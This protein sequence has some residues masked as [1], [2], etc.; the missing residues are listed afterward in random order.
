MFHD[1]PAKMLERMR[2]LERMNEA[3]KS[4]G[5][6]RF[7]RLRQIPAETG[8]FL[9]QLAAQTPRTPGPNGELPAWIEVGA[10]GGYSA[11]W[12]SLAARHAG[13]TLTT[14]EI[15]ERKFALA[16]ETFALTGVEDVV[17]LVRADA[18][19]QLPVYERIA[20]CFLDAERSILRDCY[21]LVVPRLVPGG[22]LVADNAISHRHE[23]E[24]FLAYVPTDPRVD[25]LIAPIGA[26]ELVCRKL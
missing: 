5:T 17:R 14:Y 19:T 26:G 11:L 18:L 22:M 7:D 12:L 1:I 4:D 23:I 2:A 24:D 10:S 6:E 16:S 8:K 13:Q 20:F 21:E 15:S 3:D 25:S 9:A